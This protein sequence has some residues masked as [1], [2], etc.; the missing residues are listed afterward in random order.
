MK[1]WKRLAETF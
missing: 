1:R